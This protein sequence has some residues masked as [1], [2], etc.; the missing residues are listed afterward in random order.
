MN[1]ENIDIPRLATPLERLRT[2]LR[3][4]SLDGLVILHT[5]DLRWL[6]GWE[7][8]FDSEPAHAGL[9]TDAAAK[10]HTDGRYAHA[11]RERAREQGCR[12][13]GG[14]EGR[15]LA[16]WTVDDERVGHAAFV[17]Q[18]IFEEH[19]EPGVTLRVGIE[20]DIPL[21]RYRAL[22]KAVAEQGQG[23]AAVELV[24]TTD[25]VVRLRAQKDASELVSLR[26]AQQIADAA[27]A[28]LLV[29]LRP[30]RTE[31]EC[32]QALERLMVQHGAQECSFS[33]I[34]ASGPHSA[35]P[36]AVPTGRCLQEGDLVVIDFGARYNDY[37][38]DA[39]RTLCVGEPSDEQRTLYDAVLEA[40]EAARALLA[41]GVTGK[42]AH[43]C[44]LAV[45]ARHELDEYFTHSLGHGV[46]LDIHE[47][48]S[49]SPV[50]DDVLAAGSVVTVEPGAYLPGLGG[51]RIEDCGVVTD[52]GFSSFTGL[53]R[54]L[55]VIE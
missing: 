19:P 1:A 15:A 41:P 49:L 38:S 26:R 10:L 5:S 47:L 11:M 8:V 7:Q 36:H 30:G 12:A 17:I 45:L 13:P 52:Q 42:Q 2:Q 31:V 4:E 6:T 14:G 40:H 22:N 48:P 9:V 29:W 23:K 46:G 21:N 51:V 32:A 37:C 35:N 33:T 16:P 20:D 18:R 27:F 39:T 55:I 50:S 53:T 3:A 34:V 28:D 44:A 43:E 54:E 24:E 25:L